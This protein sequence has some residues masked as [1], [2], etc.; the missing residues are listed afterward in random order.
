MGGLLGAG[1]VVA[2]CWVVC[3]RVGVWMGECLASSLCVDWWVDEWVSCGAELRPKA[4][5]AM[6]PGVCTGQVCRGLVPC[7]PT[8]N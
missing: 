6:P 5:E 8:E 4:G 3:A 7:P 2:A 1:Q